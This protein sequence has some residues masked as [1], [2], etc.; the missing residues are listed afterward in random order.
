MGMLE[1]KTCPIELMKEFVESQKMKKLLSNKENEGWDVKFQNYW[2]Q[3]VTSQGI[4]KANRQISERLIEHLG[5]FRI[6]SEN[7]V[8]KIVD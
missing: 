6:A 7:L 2:S 4:W 1:H 5:K 3:I 8:M